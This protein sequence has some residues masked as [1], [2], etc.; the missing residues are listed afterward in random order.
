MTYAPAPG[1]EKGDSMGG[2][3]SIV[4]VITGILSALIVC[5]D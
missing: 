1:P 2:A 3:V 4:A 5:G